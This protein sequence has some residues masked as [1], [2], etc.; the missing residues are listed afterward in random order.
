[1]EKLHEFMKLNYWEKD[2]E[3]TIPLKA[4]ILGISSNNRIAESFSLICQDQTEDILQKQQIEE[5]KQISEDIL[6][7]ILP[8]D[9]ISRLNQGEKDISFSVPQASIIFIDI[10]QFSNYMALLT[11][12]QLM[13]N[14][15]QIFTTYDHILNQYSLLT[16]IKIMG[17]IYMT[18]GN[19]FNPDISFSIQLSS[20]I[21]GWK[22]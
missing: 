10:V 8:R 21:R 1:V 18:V 12:D 17:N 11:P 4:T 19:L 2:D 16:K 5:A 15:S 20:F 22:G 13:F 3:S 7:Q 6:L 14:L 9:I